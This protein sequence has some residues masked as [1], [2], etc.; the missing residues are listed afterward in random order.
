[1]INAGRAK[2]FIAAFLTVLLAVTAFPAVS[3]A[4]GDDTVC[5]AFDLVR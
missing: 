2:K 1:M 4:E 3:S 5:T